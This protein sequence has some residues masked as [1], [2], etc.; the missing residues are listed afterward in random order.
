ML[1][2]DTTFPENYLDHSDFAVSSKWIDVLKFADIN[3]DR[4]ASIK[5]CNSDGIFLIYQC[6]D[7]PEYEVIRPFSPCN[8]RFCLYDAGRYGAH[9]GVEVFHRL[10]SL[11]V[12]VY[13][14]IVFTTPAIFWPQLYDHDMANRLSRVVYKTLREFY[15]ATVGGVARAHTWGDKKVEYI[16][17]KEPHVHSIVPL[18]GFKNDG[19]SYPLNYYHLKRGL[20]RLKGIY[21]KNFLKAFNFSYDGELVVYYRYIS[22][23]DPAFNKKLMNLCQYVT[24]SPLELPLRDG[25]EKVALFGF[26]RYLPILKHFQFYEKWRS[27]RWFGWMAGHVIK[28]YLAVLGFTDREVSRFF[29][30]SDWRKCPICGRGVVLEAVYFDNKLVLMRGIQPYVCTWI[31]HKTEKLV[32]HTLEALHD[33]NP[34]MPDWMIKQFLDNM[35]AS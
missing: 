15:G 10:K 22:K 32:D 7:H 20:A 19:S 16:G 12:D 35:L 5:N 27:I 29:E 23:K 13:A 18:M 26:K 24:R 3:A 21:R 34:L 30:K 1:E 25:L 33:A 2:R 17:R 11:P 14:H 6:P 4:V 28:K 9:K 31:K 8:D